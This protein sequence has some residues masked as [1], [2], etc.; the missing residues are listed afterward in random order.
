MD[1]F[2]WYFIDPLWLSAMTD[3]SNTS[4]RYPYVETVEGM[5]NYVGTNATDQTLFF[6]GQMTG[7]LFTVPPFFPRYAQLL[8]LANPLDVTV[9]PPIANPIQLGM[10][11]RIFR[12]RDD[13]QFAVEK[14][15]LTGSEIDPI[16]PPMAYI[17]QDATGNNLRRQ[18][19]GDISWS[20]VAVPKRSSGDVDLLNGGGA[21]QRIEGF[22]FFVMVYED[23][24]FEDPNNFLD[25][26]RDPRFI[27]TKLST[28]RTFNPPEIFGT[29]TV[30]IDAV[31]ADIRNDDWVMLVN[32]DD[33]GESQVGF[34]RVIGSFENEN[35]A[36]G[37]PPVFL[38]L[39]GSD[40]QL[41]IDADPANPLRETFVIYFPNVVNVFKRQLNFEF[42]SNF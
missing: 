9:T 35:P 14:N 16:D 8:D 34:Y 11:D 40:F 10:A 21:G 42:N 13:L 27:Y 18:F 31:G 36:P 37:E 33:N 17:D 28:N 15:P 26:D 23:R 5:F 12:S 4:N 30:G 25:A 19:E 20:A 1:P 6:N 3:S 2:G 39:D 7:G 22:D 38:T 41:E 24:S 29:G 32:Y